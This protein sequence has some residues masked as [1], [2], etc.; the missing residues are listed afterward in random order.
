M[1]CHRLL[2][3]INETSECILYSY[4]LLYNKSLQILL[5][6]VNILF[7]QLSHESEIQAQLSY[8]LYLGSSQSCNKGVWQEAQLR[9]NQP[10]G[11]LNLLAKFISLRTHGL[12]MV[13]SIVWHWPSANTNMTYEKQDWKWEISYL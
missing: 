4:L 1:G 11:S 13:F 12:S 6:K 8:I 9:S 3:R 5:L 10:P 7:S 2:L